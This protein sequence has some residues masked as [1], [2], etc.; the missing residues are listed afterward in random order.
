MGPK[1]LSFPK[2]LRTLLSATQMAMSQSKERMFSMTN[3]QTRLKITRVLTPK[4][5][6]KTLKTQSLTG[7]HLQIP[8]LRRSLEALQRVKLILS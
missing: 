8:E 5:G 4:N 2:T 7:L 3:L 6:Q 1:L